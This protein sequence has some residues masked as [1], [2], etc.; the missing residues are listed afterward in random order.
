VRNLSDDFGPN[1]IDEF[2]GMSILERY[3]TMEKKKY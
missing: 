3:K 1:E 2:S